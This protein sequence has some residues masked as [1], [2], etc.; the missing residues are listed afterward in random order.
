MKY[1]FCLALINYICIVLCYTAS[2]VYTSQLVNVSN[3]MST[4]L[5]KHL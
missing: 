4:Q 2:G 3:Q 5:Y 1:Y